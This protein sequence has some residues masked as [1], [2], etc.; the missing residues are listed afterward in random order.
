MHTLICPIFFP[1][2]FSDK[3]FPWS[4]FSLHLVSEWLQTHS[5]APKKP[6]ESRYVTLTGHTLLYSTNSTSSSMTT[7][8]KLNLNVPLP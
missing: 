7:P 2:D 6:F 8:W 1:I 4:S 5:I 3:T